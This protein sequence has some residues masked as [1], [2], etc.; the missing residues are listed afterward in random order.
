MKR[1]REA[2]DAAC[3]HVLLFLNRER[4]VGVIVLL[5]FAFSSG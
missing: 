1:E 2:V 3:F 4:A 5:L